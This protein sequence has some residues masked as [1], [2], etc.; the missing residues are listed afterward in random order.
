MVGLAG[1]AETLGKIVWADAVEVDYDP[2]PAVIDPEAALRPDAP[3]ARS[4]GDTSAGAGDGHAPHSQERAPVEEEELVE[5][6]PVIVERDVYAA[7]WPAW[8]VVV[9]LPCVVVMF[10]IGLITF[11]Y[12]L[13]VI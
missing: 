8:P 10:F 12:M 6:E 13:R 4:R 5:R 1:I 2:L 3:L 9:M 11:L 7:P